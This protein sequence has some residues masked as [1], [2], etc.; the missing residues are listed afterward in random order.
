MKK[1]I[2]GNGIIINTFTQGVQIIVKTYIYMDLYWRLRPTGFLLQKWF[3]VGLWEKKGG[4]TNRSND[5]LFFSVWLSPPYNTVF[6][7]NGA[8][9]VTVFEKLF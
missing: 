4:Y 5:L 6:S 7:V 8:I 9:L 2:I 1:S 3:R